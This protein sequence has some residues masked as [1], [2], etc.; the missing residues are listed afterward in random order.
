QAQKK[1]SIEVSNVQ[2]LWGPTHFVGYKQL[3][4]DDVGH[5]ILDKN[6]LYV[7]VS[8]FYAEMGGQVGDTGWV[9]STSGARTHVLNTRRT[10][11]GVHVLS[12]ANPEIFEPSDSIPFRYVV[13]A[14]RRK[15]IEGHHTVTHLLHWALHEVVSRDASQ[16]GSYVGPDK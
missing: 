6:N 12:L 11:G 2:P 3:S 9:E 8:P 5:F 4:S 13:D 15:L 14:G 10:A 7:E 1:D 16:K